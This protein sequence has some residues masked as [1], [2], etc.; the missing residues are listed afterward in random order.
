MKAQANIFCFLRSINDTKTHNAT[1]GAY[2]IQ[3]N[4]E[5][6]RSISDIVKNSLTAMKKIILN[7]AAIAT[8]NIPFSASFIVSFYDTAFT[9]H[10]P[11]FKFPIWQVNAIWDYLSYNKT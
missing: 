2:N 3:D 7:K 11:F 4:C 10:T 6:E 5:R 8:A 9:A 1:K